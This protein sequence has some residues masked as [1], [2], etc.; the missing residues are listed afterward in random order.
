M[1]CS[2]RSVILPDVWMMI[3]R[4][5]TKTASLC[6]AVEWDRLHLETF[7][8]DVSHCCAPNLLKPLEDTCTLW[9]TCF[10][11]SSLLGRRTALASDFLLW[12]TFSHLHEE[13]NVALWW[14]S[15]LEKKKKKKWKNSEHKEPSASWKTYLRWQKCKWTGLCHSRLPSP[16]PA[17]MIN[18]TH[19][20]FWMEN[21][22][23]K[24][25]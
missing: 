20:A 16:S 5:Y 25:H 7:C 4:N 23:D 9:A 14:K 10:N 19:T 6:C 17:L 3:V 18:G 8:S 21:F 11:V 1:Y 12:L 22:L 2:D 24:T 15:A 13:E